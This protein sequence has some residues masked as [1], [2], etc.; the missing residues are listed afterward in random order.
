MSFRKIQVSNLQSTTTLFNDPLIVLN[1]DETTANTSDI[2]IVFERGTS[3]NTALIWDE[4]EDHFAVITTSD[5]GGTDGNVTISSYA[6]IKANS[7]IGTFTGN[8]TGN[9]TGTTSSISNHDTDS[10]SEGSTNL[11]YTD[12]RARASLSASG[13]ISYNSSTGVIS[14]TA[15]TA[16]SSFTNDSGYIT[17]YTVTQSD[18]TTHQA[19]LSIT[20][21]QI[22]DLQSYLTSY[23]VTQSDVTTH[24]AALSITESQISDL[25]SYLTDTGDQTITD[26]STGSSAG[27]VVELYRNNASPANAN[28]LGQIKFQGKSST[29]TTRTYAKITGKIADV[30][31][32]SEDGTIEFSVLDTGSNAIPVRINENGLYLNAGYTL[33]FEGPVA[34][35]NE[36]TVTTASLNADRTI[37]MPDATGTVA[38]LESAQTFSGATTFSAS[39]NSVIIDDTLRIAQTGSGLR[40]TNVG[41]FDNDGSDNF[42]VFATNDL[43]LK[44]NGDTGAGLSIDVTNNHVTID[45][46]L[47]VGAGKLS[48]G[49]TL[50]TATATEINYTDG[51]T[52]NIQT[53]INTKQD[54]LSHNENSSPYVVSS[55]DATNND[56]NAVTISA[57]TLGFNLSGAISYSI[58]LNRLRLRSSEVSVNTSTGAL[59]FS[60]NTIELSD[61]IDAVWIT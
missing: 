3:S 4:S 15:P 28:Y 11:Y 2:G 49:G 6:D 18:V 57:N 23:T 36:L 24:Q 44:A 5:D 43:V 34:N 38:L 30:T 9:V 56:S 20:E 21:S 47:I 51:V 39:G 61:E 13:D 60:V 45:N 54:T 16:L 32:G 53:Q 35:T 10:L 26:T 31:N 41:A 19:A 1:Y 33:K 14:Y 29:G 25:G 55:T 40:M 22:S 58:F 48:Y 52:S 27:P 8:I 59:T 37:T 12:A 42:R 46:N 7:F 50:I 17:S